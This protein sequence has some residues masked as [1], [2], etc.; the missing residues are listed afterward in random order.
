M[1][2]TMLFS[3]VL[4]RVAFA[5]NPRVWQ[6]NRVPGDE[7]TQAALS[8]GQVFIR[9][10]RL[11]SVPPADRGD[12][13]TASAS[14][15]DPHISPDSAMAQAAR[16][17]KAR[18]M[19]AEQAHQLVAQFTESSDLG[20]LARAARQRVEAQFGSGPAVSVQIT[21]RAY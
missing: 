16:V 6:G 21:R 18:G 14:G 1:K 20:P 17:A 19:Q 4:M 9:S 5:Q 15:L 11:V 7:P 12:A 10:R 3:I 13:V 8:N 2:R